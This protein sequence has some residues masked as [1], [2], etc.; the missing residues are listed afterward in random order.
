MAFAPSVSVEYWQELAERRAS[1]ELEENGQ[2]AQ[3]ALIVGNLSEQ[4]IKIA[5]ENQDY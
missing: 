5:V 1:K 4:A 2:E 3:T